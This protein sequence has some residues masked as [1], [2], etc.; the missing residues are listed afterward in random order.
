VRTPTVAAPPATFVVRG[1]RWHAFQLTGTAGY[2]VA[3]A[4]AALLTAELRLSPGVMAAAALAGLAVLFALTYATAAVTGRDVIVNYHHLIVVSAVAV[5]V[6]WVGRVPVAAHVAAFVVSLMVFQGF[7][8]LGCFS[9]GCCHGR[10]AGW[11]VRYGARHGFPPPLVGV[12][13]VPT[14]LVE[15]AWAF[16]L[17]GAGS[18]LLLRG[19]PPGA[20]LAGVCAAFA[21]GRLAIE[22]LRGDA[23]RPGFAGLS[24]AQWTSVLLLC[25]VAGAAWLAGT[26]PRT[27][28]AVLAGAAVAA[29][30]AR[31]LLRR[32]NPAPDRHLLD[33][34]HVLELAGAVAITRGEAA[35]AG[36]PPT[37]AYIHLATTSRGVRGS[38]G[39]AA[40]TAGEP[41][42][43]AGP[44]VRHYTL[45][46]EPEVLSER[47]AQRLARTILVLRHPG[48]RGTLVAGRCRGTFHLLVAVAV[49]V[50]S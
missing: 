11:G 26:G 7:G 15:S 3:A 27:T 20:V 37:A 24:E 33:P 38:S 35:V 47:L 43:T 5:L 9:A 29:A 4:L 10:P 46:R 13:L 32:R 39:L 30:A 8:R 40:G 36:R 16:T 19:A 1:R 44:P 45:S 25:G 6:A 17:A 31:V 12:P 22:F 2:V 34:D 41:R 18:V 48:S 14:Q 49:T 42:G 28:L 50:T 21:T 23:G